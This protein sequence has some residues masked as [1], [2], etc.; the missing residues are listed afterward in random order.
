MGI[1]GF[2]RKNNSKFGSKGKQINGVVITIKTC[3]WLKIN[4][5][6]LRNCF[7]DGAIFP[8]I[9]YFKYF[10]GEREYL[11]KKY[12]PSIY[13]CPA[14]GEKIKLYIDEQKPTKYSVQYEFLKKN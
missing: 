3:W 1:R 9:I 11:G 6:P 10:V 7:M 2:R 4:T 12:I 14:I 13:R 5:K 8:H